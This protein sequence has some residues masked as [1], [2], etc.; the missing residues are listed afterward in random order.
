MKQKKLGLII[1]GIAII[2]GL[3]VIGF[4][5]REGYYIN[6][7]IGETGSCYLSDG[8]CLHDEE[9]ANLWMY[10]VGGAVSAA[11]LFLGIY[12]SFIDKTQEEME[13]H[14]KT[15]AKALESAK[16]EEREK[17]EFKAFLAGFTS[18]EQKVLK[19]VHEQDG[20][21]Q[22]TLRYRTD[23][24]KT[25]LSLMLANL[26]KRGFIKRIDKGKTKEVYF[27]KKF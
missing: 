20:I 12:L 18:D 7:I 10:L 22:S 4:K 5:V 17:D 3:T 14:H 8:T 25:G 24:S 27:V 6:S 23:T 15:V 2:I 19:A 13:K 16:K 1:I 11:L 9:N 21:K 26:E